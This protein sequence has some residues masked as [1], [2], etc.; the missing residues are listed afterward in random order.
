MSKNGLTDY[1]TLGCY[2]SSKHQVNKSKQFQ[3]QIALRHLL[4]HLESFSSD[5]FLFKN[6]CKLR[7]F[8]NYIRHRQLETTC[9]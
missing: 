2:K 5:F 9:V 8:L 7:C 1:N 4:T 3:R 6:F